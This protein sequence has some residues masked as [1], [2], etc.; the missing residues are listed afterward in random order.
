M[1]REYRIIPASQA[2]RFCIQVRTLK[3]AVKSS[4]RLCQPST[5]PNYLHRRQSKVYDTG[6]TRNNQ[7]TLR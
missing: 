3:G 6:V 1:K 2:G 5:H 7:R 4:G